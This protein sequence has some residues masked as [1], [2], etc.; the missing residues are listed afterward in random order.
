MIT[1]FLRYEIDP[2][3]PKEFE[4]YCKMWIPLI[5]KFGGTIEGYYMPQEGPNDIA[6]ALF[7]FPSLAAY[8][9]YRTQS[10]TDPDCR[11]AIAYARS[12][13]CVVRFERSFL[14]K[15]EV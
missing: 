5:Q 12:N 9:N 14:R 7:S 3:Q 10:A 6:L 1:C 8:E 15:L 13:K 4:T 11:K 2:Y